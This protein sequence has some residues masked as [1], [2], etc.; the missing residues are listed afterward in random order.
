[1]S[2]AIVG[3]CTLELA[4]EDNDSLKT[5]RAVL[6]S[7]IKRMRNTFNIAVAEIDEVDNPQTAILAF[8]TLS[9]SSRHI[10]QM[11]TTVLNWIDEHGDDVL[12]VNETVEVL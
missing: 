5:K 10:D 9:N 12:V 8:T 7:L 6:T 2:R 4:L 3:L 1:M 11:M